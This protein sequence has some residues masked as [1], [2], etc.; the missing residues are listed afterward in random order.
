MSHFILRREADRGQDGDL[1]RRIAEARKNQQCKRQKKTKGRG[2]W[3]ALFATWTGMS[4]DG[5]G[6]DRAQFLGCH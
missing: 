6:C 3:D 4:A 5:S 1:P 2:H